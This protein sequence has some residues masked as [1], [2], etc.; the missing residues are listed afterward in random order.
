MSGQ[1]FNH[2]PQCWHSTREI[3]SRNRLHPMKHASRMSQKLV[4]C[5]MATALWIPNAA[6]QTLPLQ[7]GPTVYNKLNVQG[8]PLSTT[9]WTPPGSNGKAP[10]TDYQSALHLP[11]ELPTPDQFQSVVALGGVAPSVQPDL[12]VSLKDQ[13]GSLPSW[14]SDGTDLNLIAS[15]PLGSGWTGDFASDTVARINYW[16]SQ[17][18]I[19]NTALKNLGSIYSSN[20]GRLRLLQSP[21]LND[22]ISNPGLVGPFASV[23]S[24]ASMSAI[25]GNAGWLGSYLNLISSADELNGVRDPVVRD[26]ALNNPNLIVHSSNLPT[27]SPLQ[28]GQGTVLLQDTQLLTYLRNPTFQA[29]I[30]TVINDA[31]RQNNL[32]LV[33]GRSNLVSFL[34]DSR[35]LSDFRTS[36]AGRVLASPTF[37]NFLPD[38]LV[39]LTRSLGDP[40]RGL[41]IGQL[42]KDLPLLLSSL[43]GG[44]NNLLSGTL[45]QNAPSVGLPIGRDGLGGAL[46]TTP[47]V[48]VGTPYVIQTPSLLMGSI[49]PAPNTDYTGKTLLVDLEGSPSPGNYWLSEPFSTNNHANDRFYWSPNKRAVFAT[50]PGQISITWKRSFPLPTTPLDGSD[51]SKY[52]RSQAGQYYPLLT[53]SYLISSSPIKSPRTI[54]WTEGDFAS[55]GVFVQVPVGLVPNGIHIVFNE[56]FPASV[57]HEFGKAPITGGTS[58]EYQ[59]TNTLWMDPQLHAIRAYNAVGRVFVELLGDAAP[60]GQSFLHLG[61]ELVDVKKS[62]IPHD[63]TNDLGETLTAWPSGVT[64][65]GG[66]DDPALLPQKP[67][68]LDLSSYVMRRDSSQPGTRLQFYATGETPTPNSVLLHWLE[69]GLLGIRW[70]YLFD[71][72]TLRWPVNPS[73]YSHY[74]RPLAATPTEAKETAIQLPSLNAPAI[75]Y[76]D[77]F[78]G[79]RAFITPDFKFYTFVDR[80]VPVHRTLLMYQANSAIYFERVYSWLDLALKNNSVGGDGRILAGTSATNLIGWD[81]AGEVIRFPDASKGPRVVNETAVV[82]RRILPPDGEIGDGRSGRTNYMAGYIHQPMGTSFSQTAYRSPLSTDGFSAAD[83]SSII[84][85]NAVPGNNQL[86]IWWF[87]NS[88]PPLTNGFT[89]IAWPEVIGY[90]T[91]QWPADASEIVLASNSGSGPL[92]SL[93]AKGRIYIQ[94]D[95]DSAGYNP[96]EEHALLQGGQVYALRDDLNITSTNGPVPYSSDPFV[97]LEYTDV[98]GRPS[99]RAFRVRR[100]APEK[101][102]TFDYAITA[103][104][105]LQPPMPLPLLEKP[106]A[107]KIVG[108][109]RQ[110]LNSEI[111]SWDVESVESA[112]NSFPYVHLNLS[113]PALLR[114][115][116]PLSFQDLSGSTYFAHWRTNHGTRQ[117][118]GWFYPIT[119]NV[120]G[121]TVSGI[122]SAVPPSPLMAVVNPDSGELAAGRNSYQVASLEDLS[123][124]ATVVLA[125]SRGRTN[126]PATVESIGI[127]I[128]GTPVIT[129]QFD[130]GHSDCWTNATA[131]IIPD[132]PSS[133]KEFTNWKL[134][135]EAVSINLPFG[136]LRDLYSGFTLK[137][138]KGNQ[139]VFRGPHATNGTPYTV[140]QFYYKTLPGFYFPSLSPTSQP[141]TGTVTPYLRPLDADGIPQ[142]EPVYG[143]FDSLSQFGDGNSLGIY[144]HPQWPTDAPVLQMAETL[145]VPKRG[146]PAVRGQSSLGVLYQQS[147]YFG[148]ISNASVVLHDPT[149]ARVHLFGSNPDST[150]VLGKIP[151]SA[152]TE[153]FQGK[154]YFPALPPHLAD[155]FYFDPNLGRYGGLSFVGSFQD[156]VV[157][158]KYLLLN[159][160]SPSDLDALTKVVDAADPLFGVWQTTLKQSLNTD[161]QRFVENPARPGTF[162]PEAG[163]VSQKDATQLAVVT[164]QDVAVD[165]YALT[166]MGPG[167]GYVALIAGNGLAFTPTDDPVSVQIFRVDKSLYKGEVKIVQSSNPLGEKLSLQQVVDLAAQTGQYEFDWRIAPPLDGSSPPVYSRTPMTLV[168][169]G[170]T[171]YHLQDV[172]PSDSI[173]SLTAEVAANPQRFI[174]DVVGSVIP[175]PTIPF[176]S[177]F[178][179]D[180][181]HLVFQLHVGN[182]HTL[183]PGNRVHVVYPNGTE[184]AGSVTTDTTALRIAIQLDPSQNYPINILVP[185]TLAPLVENGQAATYLYHDFTTSTD[186]V[187]S[188]VWLSLNL[189]DNLGA[190]V[191]LD[192]QL[193][194]SVNLA[195]G[196]SVEGMPPGDLRP[197]SHVY[198]LPPAA[199]LSGTPISDGQKSHRLAVALFSGAA[200]GAL[201]RFDLKLEGH[202]ASDQVL[203]AGS[204]W[205]PLDPVRYPDGVRAVL[206]GAA[207]VRALSDNYLIMRY[208]ATNVTHASYVADGGWSSWTDPVL[209]EGWIKRVLAGINPFNQRV[210]DLFDNKINTDASILTSAGHR[211][212]GDVALNLDSIN[213]YGLIEIYETVLRRGRLLSID[214]GINYGP[215]N[216]ALLLAAGYIS[217]L[218]KLE[219]DEA[220]ADANN[221][222][223]SIGS[224]DVSYGQVA[225]SLFPFMGQVATL[226]EEQQAMLRGRDDFSAPGVG[227]APVYNRLYWNYTRGINSGEVI[228]ALNYDIQPNPNVPLTGSITA[229]DAAHLYPQGH[230]DAYGHY[231]TSI[232]GYYSLLMNPNFSWIPQAEA[233]NV[234]GVP[235]QVNYQHER[236]FASG[237]SALGQAGLLALKLT[238]KAD[239]VPGHDDGWESLMETRSNAQTGRTRYWGTDHWANRT[240][241]GTFLNWVVGNSLLPAVDPDP[242]HQG[243]QKVDRTTVVELQRLPITGSELQTVLDNAEGGLNPLGLPDNAV[244]F[245]INPTLVTG[246][247][248]HFEQIY[249]R[250]VA[251]LANASA[252]FDDAAGVT[253][254]MRSQKDSLADYQA[255]VD[256]QERSYTNMLI[257]IYGTPYTDDIG[258]GQ[259]YVQGYGGPDLFH[260]MYVENFELFAGDIPTNSL[261]SGDP[262]ASRTFKID[263]QML[264]ANWFSQGLESEE[265]ELNIVQSNSS[266]YTAGVD[267]IAYELGPRG[268]N[269]KPEE[270]HGIRR[271]PG[272]LQQSISAMNAA[273]DALRASLTD[274]EIHKKLLDRA[275]QILEATWEAYDNI[276]KAKKAEFGLDI[277]TET[278][279]LGVEIT[280]KTLDLTKSVASQQAEV[281]KTALPTLLV[282]GL[283]N[284]GDL[285]SAARGV[286]AEAGAITSDALDA[287]AL[288][289]DSANKILTYANGLIGKTLN[290]SI[291][292]SQQ[293]LETKK[294]LADLASKVLEVREDLET[295][296]TKVRAYN[297]AVRSYRTLLGRGE[298]LQAERESFRKRAAIVIQGYRTRDVALRLFRNDKLE[299]YNS[300]FDLASTYSLL[301][302]QAFDYETGL[303]NTDKGRSFLRR[304]MSSRAIGVFNGQQPQPAG[305]GDGDPGLSS[306]LAEMKADWDVLKGRLG[307]NSPDT[308]G[309]LVSL[310]TERFRILPGQQGNQAWTDLL[311]HS[312]MDDI[313]D[314]PDVRRYCLQIDPGGGLAVPGLVV[315]FSTTIAKGL[316]V[317]GNPIAGGDHSFPST[318]FATKIF[319]VGVSFEGYIGMDGPLS[320]GGNSTN[321]SAYLNPYA[322]AATPEVYLIPVGVDSMRSPPLG[323]T[324]NVRTWNIADIAVPLPFNIGGTGFSTQAIW[325]ST[326]SLSEPLFSERKHPAFRPVDGSAVF[327]NSVLSGVGSLQR[328]QYTSSRLIGRSVWNSKWKIVIPGNTLL[329]DP[330]EGLDRFIRTVSDIRVLYQTYSY[331][332]N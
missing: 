175:F 179:P 29:A 140:L 202:V 287:T 183:L 275:F 55:T 286:V 126:A 255:S 266:E 229:A 20:P 186:T 64:P 10:S 271:S 311:S 316:N 163:T 117:S 216:D 68:A 289:L 27:L 16:K 254:L 17:A 246:G 331:S 166:A 84:P 138:R 321:S 322:L 53:V 153:Q 57:D 215:A 144:Y 278:A 85:V 77:E 176:D 272:Q 56:Q 184:L 208:R 173:E 249:A 327:R 129:V 81:Q 105:V 113:Q 67:V 158:D 238:T 230:G 65:Q 300:L 239:Y 267:Y 188:D 247:T 244:A 136:T 30:L 71:R 276:E 245:D 123:A 25:A 261:F 121:K 69:S 31:D 3:A 62:P 177:V 314:D 279:K 141:P 95:P 285:F 252:S 87:R 270:W 190:R 161:L 164:D 97:L 143:N 112:G 174:P 111:S 308:Y 317:F 212:E 234:L 155:R 127:G 119:A 218:Y 268:F 258:P 151:S 299:R 2:H 13:R 135:P 7:F 263:R 320:N 109:Q 325:Q 189:D 201:L 328:S 315:P 281:F 217:D 118:S 36:T 137:D 203:V 82:G 44:A 264:P 297:D 39:N 114:L 295:I 43:P 54:Y 228:Y 80:M 26:A 49:I 46:V 277:V 99:Q 169:S 116:Q 41:G 324:S 132:Q 180:S 306:A 72:Y 157:G 1:V 283:A 98:D 304:I 34:Q 66:V 12:I 178:Q 193:L 182:S 145:T 89:P 90:Y 280:E 206:G 156:D 100:E 256:S 128:D 274:A 301:A 313:L 59:V 125:D 250:A 222:T 18:A 305:S 78:A 35:L 101:G 181:T 38:D 329:N 167:S 192:G 14:L 58:L 154:T 213:S 86:E 232:T 326:Q 19:I 42:E 147:Q 120:H 302:A 61:F 210:T 9:N 187:L 220:W 168:S 60:D 108:I 79:S 195:S 312:R 91:V 63:V 233:V 221:P 28:V 92:P 160:L 225:T 196:N 240:A 288:G 104:S 150:T 5:L 133:E 198:R 310:R 152:R 75:V 307:F 243:V 170:S 107:P 32:A 22:L 134:S 242:A 296:N 260:Y 284:G 248:N 236:K 298:R 290:F 162:T 8:F 282:V 131:L 269:G 209:A 194:S 214:G 171:W 219:G 73:A 37:I 235:V 83:Q 241:Q 106:L 207:D 200:P 122:A 93:E 257:E 224:K 273:Y 146:L 45:A 52:Y 237:A 259:T 103:G 142:G 15:L 265:S 309:T 197:L 330:N 323:D 303:L 115:Y 172:R 226:M 223:I 293:N 139:W 291:E 294:E 191:Y 47:V 23:A 6:A 319:S 332:G 110:T 253:R 251:A 48:Q 211:W 185:E 40:K 318:A 96:N 148:G 199:L 70:P 227:I 204:Q 231:L 130:V 74:V 149:R 262:Q 4:A 94:N 21:A 11:I 50:Q 76:Q 51:A 205:L 165:S 24:D 88:A 102:Q 159:V 124:G 33:S 292:L